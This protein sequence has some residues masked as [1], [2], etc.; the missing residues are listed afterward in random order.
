[1]PDPTFI[2]DTPGHIPGKTYRTVIT[3]PGPTRFQLWWQENK[4]GAT[5]VLGVGGFLIVLGLLCYFLVSYD[6]KDQAEREAPYINSRDIALAHVIKN[7]G[8]GVKHSSWK[9]EEFAAGTGCFGKTIRIDVASEPPTSNKTIE[10]S[11]CCDGKVC[12]MFTS[13]EF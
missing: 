12:K 1:M 5:V 2:P 4:F 8:G 6:L 3:I 11:F 9:Y 7:M 13:K 10:S